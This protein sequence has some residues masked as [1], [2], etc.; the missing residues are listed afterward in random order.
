MVFTYSWNDNRGNSTEKITV[1]LLFNNYVQ[2]IF[3][4]IKACFKHEVPLSEIGLVYSLCS[5]VDSLLVSIIKE[6]YSSF[7]KI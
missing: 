5:H 6:N 7:A 3:E 4:M 1:I 2:R